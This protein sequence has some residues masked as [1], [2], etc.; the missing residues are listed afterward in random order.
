MPIEYHQLLILKWITYVSFVSGKLGVSILDII[1]TIK[2]DFKSY[3][4]FIKYLEGK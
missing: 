4:E 3:D 2:K 1:G